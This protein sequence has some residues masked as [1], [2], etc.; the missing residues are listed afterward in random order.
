MA[1]DRGMQVAAASAAE[2]EHTRAL[3]GARQAL[4]ALRSGGETEILPT[5]TQRAGVSPSASAQRPIPLAHQLQRLH[6][7]G[8]RRGSGPGWPASA[9]S[10]AFRDRRPRRGRGAGKSWRR[11]ASPGS[12]AP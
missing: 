4:L 10:R 1:Q 5:E 2:L 7:D 11:G 12:P 3:I 9:P 6:P 8:R